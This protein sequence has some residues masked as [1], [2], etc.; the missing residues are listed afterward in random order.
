MAVT[1]QKSTEYTNATASPVTLNEA[2]VYHGRVRIAYFTHDQDGTGDAGSSVALFALPAGKVKVL[3]AA[4]RAY[5]NWTTTSATLDLGW[6]AYTDIDGDAVAADP[7]GLVDGLDVDTVGYQTLEGALAGIKA[8]GG[9][10]TF[11]TQGG[12]V[13]RATSPTAMV[14]GD[15]LVGYILYVVD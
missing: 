9:T 3:L 10:Y 11:E 15:D 12:V 2:N 1:T 8:T 14:D 4:S 6:D 7:D 13:I 5:V